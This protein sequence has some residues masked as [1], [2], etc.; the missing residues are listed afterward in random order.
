MR[1]DLTKKKNPPL[2]TRV[3]RRL[4]TIHLYKIQVQQKVFSWI[5]TGRKESKEREERRRWRKRKLYLFENIESSS[6]RH[7]LWVLSFAHFLS[8]F[9][10]RDRKNT[11]F[12]FTL[13]KLNVQQKFQLF[14]LIM[15]PA[16]EYCSCI[17]EYKIFAVLLILI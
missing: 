2:Q 6:Y 1:S 10:S 7:I 8:W 14:S 13:Q 9:R 11:P 3:I 5:K 12:H 15:E 17:V 16:I 4:Y